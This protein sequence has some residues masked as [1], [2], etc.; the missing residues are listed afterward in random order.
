MGAKGYGFAKKVIRVAETFNN[1]KI[2]DTLPKLES[3]QLS[4]YEL[5][6]GERECV[7][8]TIKSPE[9]I[10]SVAIKLLRAKTFQVGMVKDISLVNQY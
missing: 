2:F 7:E 8:L 6:Y 10:Y 5:Q 1:E 3:D 4:D 9:S